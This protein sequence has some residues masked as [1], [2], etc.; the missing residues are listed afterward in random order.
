MWTQEWLDKLIKKGYKYAIKIN[1]G[2]PD[3]GIWLTKAIRLKNGEFKA[4]SNFDMFELDENES[5]PF[6]DNVI[7]KLN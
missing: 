3:D 4:N 2:S 7:V 5:Y 1:K 6:E